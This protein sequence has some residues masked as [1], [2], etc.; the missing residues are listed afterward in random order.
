MVKTARRRE[1]A[2]A[3]AGFLF[4][5]LAGAALGPVWDWTGRSRAAA[6]FCVVNSSVWEQMK[7]VF[8][9]AFAF[10]MVELW[11]QDMRGFLAARGVSLWTGAA[12]VPV[13]H[14]TCLGITGRAERWM[15]AAVLLAAS[16]AVF[17]LDLPLRRT[18]RL[19]A[20]WQQAA[21]LAALWLP[22]LVFVLWTYRPPRLPL[23]LDMA[24][25]LFGI[26]GPA[27]P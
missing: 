2:W 12:L 13:L 16:A 3:M 23:F 9:P 14:Y 8:L 6:A 15:D 1:L 17:C 24:A 20:G 7:R 18:G 10:S 27:G 26:P 5:L 11:F 25:G 4:T 21:G 22:V 19:T